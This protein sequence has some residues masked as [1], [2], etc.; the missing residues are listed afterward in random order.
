MPIVPRPSAEVDIDSAL[1]GV[2]LDEQF[3]TIASLPRSFVAEGWDNVLWRIGDDLVA[4]LPRRAVA[5]ELVEREQTWLPELAPRLP[6]TVPVPLYR[7]AP[8]VRYPWPWSICRWTPGCTAADLPPGPDA[9]GQLGGFL[10]ALHQPAPPEAPPNPWR[11]VPLHAR[12]ERTRESLAAL[13]GHVD[14]PALGMA[15]QA[16]LEVPRWNGPPV[17][18]HGDLHPLNVIVEGAAADGDAEGAPSIAAV[19]DW[20]DLTSGDPA[21][22]LAIGWSLFDPARRA[23]FRRA[24]GC[25]RSTWAR[26][27][28]WALALGVVYLANSADHPL[29]RSIGTTMLDA[30]LAEG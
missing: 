30:V 12:D 23:E 17:W 24:A 4:R 2:L 22:D 13:A 18:L 27:R 11:G 3:P 20:G 15:W 14:V 21:C 8:S 19:I 28:G 26:A 7:G 10:R 5:A 16:A 29:L 25:D 1:L 6:I 9:A